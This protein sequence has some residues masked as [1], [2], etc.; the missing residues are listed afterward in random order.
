MRGRRGV[1]AFELLIGFFFIL[2]LFT[3]IAALLL[4]TVTAVVVVNF[5]R[6]GELPLMTHVLPYYILLFG[7]SIALLFLGPGAVAVDLPL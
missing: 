6:R 2:G 3:Q 5:Y 1:G 7:A 4:A